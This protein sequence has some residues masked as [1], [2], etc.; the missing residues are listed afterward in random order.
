[1]VITNATLENTYT[2]NGATV[3]YAITIPYFASADIKATLDGVATV[4]FTVTNGTLQDGHYENGT[5]TFD[6]APGSGVAIAIYV[7][8]PAKQEDVDADASTVLNISDVEQSLD[9]FS[10]VARDTR[11][12]NNNNLAETTAQATAAAASAT[13]AAASAAAAA[14]SETAAAA[15]Q[16]SA[17]A[18]Q[19]SATSSASSAATSATNAATSAAAAETSA[20]NA[21]AIANGTLYTYTSVSGTVSPADGAA[22]T[23]VAD[24]TIN[25]PTPAA[26]VHIRLLVAAT[27]AT[28]TIEPNGS[29]TITLDNVTGGAGENAQILPRGGFYTIQC[30]DSTNWLVTVGEASGIYAKGELGDLNDLADVDATS[31]SNGQTLAFNSI[32]GNWEPSAAG[33]GDVT[34]PGSSTDNAVA[35]FD[36]TTGKIIQ[37]SAVTI[38]DSGNIAT[39]GTVDG[40]DVSTDGTK[41]DTIETNA[42]VTDTANVTSAGAAILA[43]QSGGQTLRGG[44]AASDDLTLESTSNATKGDIISS[45][46]HQFNTTAVFDAEVDNG[47]SGTADTIDWTAGNK[48]RSTLTGNVTY[49]F[50]A[51]A[52]PCNLIFKLIQDGTGS[53]TATF[54]ASVKW[55]GGTAPTLTTTASAIDIVSFYYD[56]TDYYGQAGL[57]FS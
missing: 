22:I 33:A 2:G 35:R 4:D 34:G 53:R 50:T 49:T 19:A 25:L 14:A 3:D 40:R 37:N 48:Q 55:A 30:Y 16:S 43:G 26:N 23:F 51:P 45:G 32:S 8:T 5:V 38:D 31:P 18:S 21:S 17:S 39:S 15:S 6:T 24:G 20:G 1:M 11:R 44:T 27:N 9:R 46:N 41:L 28:I 57:D 29:E 36:S 52:G 12:N 56:G 47:N 54:P 42:D 7:D 13:A 10:L